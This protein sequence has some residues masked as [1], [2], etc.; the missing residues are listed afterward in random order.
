[1]RLR[2]ARTPTIKTGLAIGFGLTVALWLFAGVQFNR[3]MDGLRREASEI[4]ARYSRA[5]EQLS[6]VNQQILIGSVLVRDAVLSLPAGGSDAIAPR[7]DNVYQR[8]ID[9]INEYVPVLVSSRAER[10]RLEQ[11]G[12]DINALR[13]TMLDV[14][15]KARTEGSIAG[16]AALLQQVRPKRDLILQVTDDIRRLNRA[17]FG[18]QQEAIAALYHRTEQQMWA[19]LAFATIASLFIGGGAVGYAGRLESN[20]RERQLREASHARDLQ[21]LSAQVMHVQEDERRH[22]ARELHDEVGQILTAIKMELAVAQRTMTDAGASPQ[23]LAAARSLAD[24]GLAS[25][26][27]L[28]HLLHPS[29]LDDL[30]LPAALARLIDDFSRRAETATTLTIDGLYERLPPAVEAAV[31]RVIQEALTNVARHAHSR[32]CSVRLVRTDTGLEVVIADQGRGFDVV[33]AAA[34]RRSGLGLLGMKERVADLQGTLVIES[35][36]ES[37]TSVRIALPIPPRTPPAPPMGD[38]LMEHA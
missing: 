2:P 21:R 34:D 28:S 9:S 12:R 23:S 22:I 31:Y 5:Q 13:L 20:L 30:G 6:S 19:F 33:D 25:V 4:A 14:A 10:D 37:G 11:V 26:R 16:Q 24:D 38:A 32:T 29:L 7:L 1:M 27:D 8:A 3:R 18:Q 17:A 35:A 15:Q 36:I